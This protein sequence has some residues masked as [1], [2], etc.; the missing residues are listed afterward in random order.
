MNRKICTFILLAVLALV[1]GCNLSE[2]QPPTATPPT[3]TARYTLT[4]T[5]EP[6]PTLTLASDEQA[7]TVESN[8]PPEAITLGDEA[9]AL[10]GDNWYVSD[11]GN[12][13]VI[14]LVQNNHDAPADMVEAKVTLYNANGKVIATE[15]FASDLTVLQPGQVSPFQVGFY[16]GIPADWDSYEIT[17]T[18]REW[19]GLFPV[20]TDFEVLSHSWE[21]GIIGVVQNTGDTTAETIVMPV[22]LYDAS[23]KLIGVGGGGTYAN[24][25]APGETAEFT[26]DVWG[27]AGEEWARYE[28]FFEA[29]PVHH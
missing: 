19:D 25:L 26:C 29:Y 8:G 5:P 16:D 28:F 9:L 6:Q 1:T 7:A 15:S 17:L 4:D 22:A 18:G 13:Y 21:I 27:W 3:T 24:T 14:G 23:G 11:D 2:D 12:F 10:V 20:Y